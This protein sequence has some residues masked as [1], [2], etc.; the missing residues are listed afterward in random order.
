MRIDGRIHLR[1]SPSHHIKVDGCT[2]VRV[3]GIR[4]E[5]PLESPNTDGINF[6]GGQDQLLADSVI[7]NGDD[8]VS[9]VPVGLNQRICIVSPQLAAAVPRR[10]HGRVQRL[11]PLLRTRRAGMRM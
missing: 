8:C 9:V 6:Y 5:A 10:Q 7:S 1:D 4:I 2:A 3:T 11:V